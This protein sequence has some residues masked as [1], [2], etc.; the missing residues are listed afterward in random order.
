MKE[1]TKTLWSMNKTLV[2]TEESAGAVICKC[3]VNK[4]F[5]QIL[6]NSQENTCSGVSF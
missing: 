4:A 1:K 6:Q 5:W 3:S 2:V